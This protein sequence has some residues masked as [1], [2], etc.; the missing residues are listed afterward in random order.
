MKRPHLTAVA[1]WP[2]REGRR[3]DEPGTPGPLDGG[4][5]LVGGPTHE[6][7]HDPRPGDALNGPPGGLGDPGRDPEAFE[8]FESQTYR[9][10]CGGHHDPIDARHDEYGR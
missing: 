9:G 6:L 8:L 10:R 3:H 4:G 5:H 2:D 7:R 1:G